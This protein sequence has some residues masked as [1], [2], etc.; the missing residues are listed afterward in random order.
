MVEY[1]F[2][3]HVF[4]FTKHPTLNECATIMKDLK[5]YER[6]DVVD[7]LVKTSFIL[8][9]FSSY[10]VVLNINTKALVFV[11]VDNMVSLPGS[12][13]VGVCMYQYKGFKRYSHTDWL[14]KDLTDTEER[15]IKTKYEDWKAILNGNGK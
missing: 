13:L 6:D 11:T 2:R 10:K 9:E 4:T 8:D 7:L 3:K 14:Y 1:E 15:F 12:K 5:D